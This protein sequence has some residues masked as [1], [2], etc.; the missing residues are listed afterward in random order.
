M[1]KEM[2]S[3][4]RRQQVEMDVQIQKERDL[5]EELRHNYRVAVRK[6]IGLQKELGLVRSIERVVLCPEGLKPL[7][8][9]P[10]EAV[11]LLLLSDW[12]VDEI[13]LP[14]A[15][16]NLNEYNLDIAKE[17]VE[18]IFRSALIINRMYRGESK[19]RRLVVG[20]L[21][22]F[23]SG[24]IHEELMIASE[25]APTE[26]VVKVFEWLIS[27]LNFLYDEGDFKEID[28]ICCTGNHGRITKK[29]QYKQRNTKSYEWILYSFLAKWYA[30][31]K[32]RNI[33]FKLPGGYFNWL[34]IYGRRVRFHH[35]DG[36]DYRGG[37]GGIHIPLHKA[38]A[39]WNEAN[40][41]D[42]DVMGHWHSSKDDRNYVINGSVIGYNEYAE[43]KKCDYE[44]PK[45]TM[46][47]MHPRYGKTGVF[48]LVL[49]VNGESARKK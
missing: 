18:R 4:S 36:I 43:S 24:W 1:S 46:L 49:N 2:K 21:G 26:S 14:E 13:V 31:D 8:R 30:A 12:H 10:L 48:N 11:P 45:Q 27:G 22:D 34:E 25:M 39:K 32:K 6:I 38:I 5:N 44:E 33:K 29:R 9:D 3:S 47:L 23:F 15:I 37:V 28:V 35:G 16:N 41:A 42:L 17:R 7:G 19:I 20:L 40:R